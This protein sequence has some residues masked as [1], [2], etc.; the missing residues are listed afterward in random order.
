MES[1]QEWWSG[2]STVLKIYW[3]L[4]IPFTALFLLQLVLSLIGGDFHDD[5]PDADIDADHGAGFQFFTLKNLIGFFTVFGWVG[6][7][8]TE[9]GSSIGVSVLVATLAGGT[10]MLVMAASFYLLLKAQHDGTMKIEKAVGQTG[11]VYL[12]IQSK[13]GSIGKVQV[14]VMGVLRTLDALTDDESDI[15]TGKIV[16]VASIVNEN[17]LLVTS[18]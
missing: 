11:E 17:L 1:F 6:I 14:K 3:S 15:Q 9:N 16:R 4:A 13:R 7:A 2:L 18:R 10:M 8:M 5:V 12:T